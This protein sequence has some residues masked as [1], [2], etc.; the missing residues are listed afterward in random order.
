MEVHIQENYSMVKDMVK[1]IIIALKIKVNIMENL[2]MVLN[3]GMECYNLINNLIIKDIFIKD[4]DME[5]EK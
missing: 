4:I 1:E 3:M 5:K 2:K